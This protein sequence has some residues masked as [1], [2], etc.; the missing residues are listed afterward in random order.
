M[1]SWTKKPARRRK[2]NQI[3]LPFRAVGVT[4]IFLKRIY[5]SNKIQ[6]HKN[7]SMKYQRKI[8][9]FYKRYT[10]SITRTEAP[11]HSTKLSLNL[12]LSK[13]GFLNKPDAYHQDLT[14]S[15]IIQNKRYAKNQDKKQV[16]RMPHEETGQTFFAEFFDS[17]SNNKDKR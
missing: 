7:G 2:S 13:I 11:K 1:K 16:R 5:M 17:F 8:Y 3:E 10:L 14:S 6:P 4:P 9:Y 12:F 15:T